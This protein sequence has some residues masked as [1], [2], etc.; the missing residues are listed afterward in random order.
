MVLLDSPGL[1]N[2][3]PFFILGEPAQNGQIVL[4]QESLNSNGFPTPSIFE[5]RV[6][7]A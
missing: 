5:A 3:C 2:D 6:W 7:G 4:F 1:E